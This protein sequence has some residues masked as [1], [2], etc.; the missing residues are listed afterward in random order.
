MHMTL[1][2]Y[3]LREF[4][5]PF[6]LHAFRFLTRTHFTPLLGTLPSNFRKNSGAVRT[7]CVSITENTQKNAC[8]NVLFLQTKAP[9]TIKTTY[10]SIGKLLWAKLAVPKN[11]ISSIRIFLHTRSENRTAAPPTSRAV[12]AGLRQKPLASQKCNA[13]TNTNMTF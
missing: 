8:I 4:L 1:L 10:Q 2:F 9:S 6:V 13:Q 7:Q 12:G 11:S 5:A 3:V